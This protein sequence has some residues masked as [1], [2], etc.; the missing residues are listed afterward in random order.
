MFTRP[1]SIELSILI[2]SFN[3]C[4]QT[5]ACLESVLLHPPAC[6][7]EVIIH[8]NA[9]SDGSAAAIAAAFPQ[10]SL[11]QSTKNLGFAQGNNHA[12]VNARGSRLLLLNPDTIVAE[13][14]LAALWQFAENNPAA[15]IWGGRT[16][17]ADGRLNPASCWGD[18]SLWS[19]FCSTFGLTWLRPKSGRFNPEAFGNWQ[20]DAVRS[21]DIVSGCFLLID[22]HLWNKLDGFDPCFF[23]YAE[24]ADLCWRAR[25][26][27]A[28][29][30]ITPAATIVHL[31]GASEASHVAKVMK[32]HRGRITLIRK[33][34]PLAKRSIGILLY[35]LWALF[36]MIAAYVVSGPRDGAGQSISK[37][38]TI[39]AQRRIWLAGY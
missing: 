14:S 38:R 34:W 6:S 22:R 23:M 24:E 15:G 19:L 37:W 18:L 8:D 35:W 33:H 30:M 28:R 31:G 5:L 10:F 3:C 36:R 39:W 9:S 27:G 29:P 26:H 17:F 7:F 25:Q 12:A 13:Q 20:R 4:S 32:I 16:L 1:T 2:V 21:V 11:I